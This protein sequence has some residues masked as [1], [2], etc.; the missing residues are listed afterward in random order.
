LDSKEGN[1]VGEKTG[2]SW[3][4]A[5]WNCWQG[6]HKVSA[7]CKNCY[8]FSE[9]KRYGQEPNVVF[10]SAPSTFRAPLKWAKNRE[11]YAH[12]Q[13]VFVCSWS[14]FFIE[15]ADPWRLE[16]WEIMRRTPELTYQICTKRSERIREC[17]PPDWHDG[18]PNVWMGTTVEN[19]EAKARIEILKKIPARLRFLSCEPLLEELGELNL[20]GIGWVITGGESGAQARPMDPMWAVKIHEQCAYWGVPYFHKQNGEFCYQSARDWG[21]A[22]DGEYTEWGNG[23]MR[24]VGRNAAGHLLGGLEWHEFPT[25]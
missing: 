11:K 18:L 15:E 24:R 21:K 22:F 19:C 16:A 6:C 3:T 7:G 4:D 12:I 17:L 25:E 8:M 13:R 1:D 20:E 5:T 23:W 2:I 10:R 9:K 14:D